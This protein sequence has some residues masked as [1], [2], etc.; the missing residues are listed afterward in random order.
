[1]RVRLVHLED[2]AGDRDLVA[3][4]LRGEGID[5]VVVAAAS[6]E[7]FERA[8]DDPPDLIFSDDSIPV[9]SGDEAQGLAQLLD[10]DGLGPD[11]VDSINQILRA[12]EQMRSLI[13]GIVGGTQAS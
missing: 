7:D 4:T 6:R 3:R 13:D 10:V 11:Q 9:F 5:C 12:G 2:D 1:M 8:L